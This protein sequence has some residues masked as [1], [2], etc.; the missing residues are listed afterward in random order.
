MEVFMK[1]GLKQMS[2][3]KTKMEKQTKWKLGEPALRMLM[4]ISVRFR[5]FLRTIPVPPHNFLSDDKRAASSQNQ[6][7][8]VRQTV[9][10]PSHCISR[11]IVKGDKGCC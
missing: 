5:P 2:K 9:E 8:V 1:V 11:Q 6:M 3:L 7:F 10:L 4:V